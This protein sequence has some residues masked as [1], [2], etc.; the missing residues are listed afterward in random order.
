MHR[1]MG[2]GAHDCGSPRVILLSATGNEGSVGAAAHSNDESVLQLKHLIGA[3]GGVPLSSLVLCSA[4][5]LLHDDGVRLPNARLTAWASRFTKV[6]SDTASEVAEAQRRIIESKRKERGRPWLRFWRAA[7]L[8]GPG[9]K[10]ALQKVSL[11]T[12]FKL[13][14]WLVLMLTCRHYRLGQPFVI[15]TLIVLMLSNLGERKLGEASAYTV[16]NEDM[17]PLPGQLRL[18]DFEREMRHA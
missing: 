9:V 16:F 5:K 4:G 11:R 17:Q 1:S 2:G 14:L 6:R 13:S 3:A 15:T 18:E 7:R 8:H 12:W 10:A